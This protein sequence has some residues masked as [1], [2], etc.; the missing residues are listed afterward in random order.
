MKL[1]K[2]LGISLVCF[3]FLNII[4]CSDDND[5]DS[6]VYLKTEDLY[7]T[8]WRG[9]FHDPNLHQST[10]DIGLEFTTKTEGKGNYR[11]PE[12]DGGAGPI[13]FTYGIEGK[14]IHLHASIIILGNYT[15]MKYDKKDLVLQ[16]NLSSA[17]GKSVATITLSRVN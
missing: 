6:N 1:K 4:S 12:G 7:Q 9:T 2:L 10:A 15:V 16:R 5:D 13:V 17:D 14:I 11:Y 3:C 8:V